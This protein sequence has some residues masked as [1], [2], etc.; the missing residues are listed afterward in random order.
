[1][2][3]DSER[4][5][6][7]EPVITDPCNPSPCGPNANCRDGACTCIAEY[8]GDPYQGCRPECVLSQDCSRDKACIRQKCIDPCPGTCG[9]NAQCT[10]SNHIPMCSCS[11]GFTGSPFIE[12]RPHRGRLNF[13]KLKCIFHIFLCHR[14]QCLT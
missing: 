10:V 11:P 1:M 5:L 14:I 12:C 7:V 4:L 9:Q 2:Y 6:I 13:H 8:H 3:S